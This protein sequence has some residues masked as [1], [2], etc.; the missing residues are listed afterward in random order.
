MALCAGLRLPKGDEIFT[1]VE[2]KLVYREDEKWREFHPTHQLSIC[3]WTEH[4]KKTSH[5]FLFHYDSIILKFCQSDR[6]TFTFTLVL[7]LSLCQVTFQETLSH[8]PH[9]SQK[10]SGVITQ[11]RFLVHFSKVYIINNARAKLRDLSVV[12]LSLFMY[13]KQGAVM[14]CTWII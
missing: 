6:F 3:K 12:A 8:Y 1:E 7:N 5:L 9:S 4:N 2:V 14:N 10:H 13:N 11:I